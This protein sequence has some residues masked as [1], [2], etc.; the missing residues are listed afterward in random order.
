MWLL[1][2]DIFMLFSSDYTR[3][4]NICAS[5]SKGDKFIDLTIAYD[6]FQ[7]TKNILYMKKEAYVEKP[8]SR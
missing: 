6:T 1:K 7:Q 8:F 2:G 5:I 3:D 4:F